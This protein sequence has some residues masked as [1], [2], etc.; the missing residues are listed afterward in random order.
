MGETMPKNRTVSNTR[1]A[2]MPMVVRIATSEAPSRIA[3]TIRST[4][5]RAAKSGRSFRKAYVPARK[6][7]SSATTMPIV[8]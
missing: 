5:L 7:I 2:R 1:L 6:A 4:L 8:L 3:M